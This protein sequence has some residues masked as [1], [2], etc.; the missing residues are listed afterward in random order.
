VLG[1]EVRV[2]VRVMVR[3][4][5]GSGSGFQVQGQGFR[6][7]FGL[8]WEGRATGHLKH[9]KRRRRNSKTASLAEPIHG[10]KRQGQ[11]TR[12]NDSA[13]LT[14]KPRPRQN[15]QENKGGS[16]LSF[17]WFKIYDDSLLVSN[18]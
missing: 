6:L 10:H 5:V 17:Y 12:Y 11:D 3:V 7:E 2:R 1:L 16:V 14:R 4:R 9:K 15:D 18:M 8:R 13:P